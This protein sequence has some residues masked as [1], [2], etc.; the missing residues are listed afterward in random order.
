MTNQTAQLT[1]DGTTYEFP[2]LESTTGE[3]AVDIRSLLKK[4]GHI[5]YEHRFMRV[6]HHLSGW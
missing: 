3:K 5:T 2:I 1:L 4:T 6:R